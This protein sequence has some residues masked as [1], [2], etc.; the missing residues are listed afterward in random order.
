MKIKLETTQ[1]F[2]KKLTPYEDTTLT[3]MYRLFRTPN[4]KD[5]CILRAQ[6]DKIALCP[7]MLKLLLLSKWP[8]KILSGAQSCDLLW[9]FLLRSGRACVP[10]PLCLPPHPPHPHC[11]HQSSEL[12]SSRSLGWLLQ[13]LTGLPYHCS[14]GHRLCV[15]LY[16][17]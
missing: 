5:T 17:H 8:M 9:C 11:L 10:G 12:Q 15:K 3:D 14:A 7:I 4:W 1:G 2:D 13:P 6:C 16:S